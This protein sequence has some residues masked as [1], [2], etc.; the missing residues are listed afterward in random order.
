MNSVKGEK[1]G[2]KKGKF[3]CFDPESSSGKFKP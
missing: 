2:I 1:F 3:N